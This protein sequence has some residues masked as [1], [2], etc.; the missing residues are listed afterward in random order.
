[1]ILFGLYS[2]IVGEDLV[3][4]GKNVLSS[5]E[6]EDEVDRNEKG[7]VVFSFFWLFG[8]DFKYVYFFFLKMYIFFGFIICK[9][10]VG[11]VRLCMV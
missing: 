3:V 6:E 9:Y 7:V 4:F 11:V 5:D 10:W 8:S 2:V 1:M